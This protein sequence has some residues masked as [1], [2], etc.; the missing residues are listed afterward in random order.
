[1]GEPKCYPLN[2]NVINVTFLRNIEHPLVFQ[3]FQNIEV[4]AALSVRNPWPR[5]MRCHDRP[6]RGDEPDIRWGYSLYLAL[7]FYWTKN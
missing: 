3:F 4:I 7:L 5:I 1:M 6:G 2:V